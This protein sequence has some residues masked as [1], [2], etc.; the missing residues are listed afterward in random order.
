[1]PQDR[2]EKLEEVCTPTH[3][4]AHSWVSWAGCELCSSVS[5]G[6]YTG[7][8]AGKALTTYTHQQQGLEKWDTAG[9][10]ASLRAPTTVWYPGCRTQVQD[11]PTSVGWRDLCMIRH[12]WASTGMQGLSLNSCTYWHLGTR[13]VPTSQQGW[14]CCPPLAAWGFAAFWD[15]PHPLWQCGE[16]GKG[17]RGSWRQ[18]HGPADRLSHQVGP[19]RFRAKHLTKGISE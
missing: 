3:A 4:C 16:G 8:G 1:M 5:R 2:T 17:L 9:K 6:V 11:T 10:R 18:N 15:H 13:A 14:S 19:T 7:A 12:P